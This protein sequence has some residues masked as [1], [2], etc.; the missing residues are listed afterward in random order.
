MEEAEKAGLEGA[1]V[2]AR[3]RGGSRYFPGKIRRENRDGTYDIDYD[4]GEKERGVQAEL[5][6]SMD[7][8]GGGGGSGGGDGYTTLAWVRGY[9]PTVISSFDSSFWKRK[10]HTNSCRGW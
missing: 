3:Y 7:G 1:K 5:I 6:K 10:L 8:G 9:T 2:E 4:D